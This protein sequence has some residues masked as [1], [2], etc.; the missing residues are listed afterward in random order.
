MLD[1]LRMKS[2]KPI[3][4]WGTDG[5]A[6]DEFVEETLGGRIPGIH[7]KVAMTLIRDLSP[8]AQKGLQERLL[9]V[10]DASDFSYRAGEVLVRDLQTADRVFPLVA[11]LV[12]EV[13]G[14]DGKDLTDRYLRVSDTHEAWCPHCGSDA[15]LDVTAEISVR[16]IRGGTSAAEARDVSHKWDDTSRCSCSCGWSGT[17]AQAR[18]AHGQPQR[19]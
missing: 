12:A 7:L 16:L 9:T 3:R 18:T 2:R 14:V 8:A 10:I 13:W 1:W 5:P 19:V 15:N 11:G 17:V 6:S 4:P